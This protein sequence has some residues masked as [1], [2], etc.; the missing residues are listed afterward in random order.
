MW[1]LHIGFLS[2]LRKFL[3]LENWSS[4]SSG[5]S[6]ALIVQYAVTCRNPLESTE[7]EPATASHKYQGGNLNCSA[8]EQERRERERERDGKREI[9]GG[10]EEVS[11]E[12]K[13]ELNMC[14]REAKDIK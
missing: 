12:G 11:T 10:A 1:A 9:Q 6:I 3:H 2:A 14:G 13:V 8:H 4:H 7:V 5:F